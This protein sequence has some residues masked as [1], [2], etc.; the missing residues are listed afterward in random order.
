M[1]RREA[2]THA[3]MWMNLDNITLSERRKEMRGCQGLGGG[4]N[5]VSFRGDEKCSEISDDGHT[6]L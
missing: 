5:R 3:T 1:K 2:L 6:I 4:E